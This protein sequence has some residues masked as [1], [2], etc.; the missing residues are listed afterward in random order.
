MKKTVLLLAAALFAAGTMAFAQNV[1][2][3][4]DDVPEGANPEF[5]RLIKEDLTRASAN[6]NS[7]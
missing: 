1:Q 4:V 5:I 3:L 6:M 2:A 7:Y